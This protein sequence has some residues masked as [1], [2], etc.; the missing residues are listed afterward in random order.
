MGKPFVI[1]VAGGTGSGK[2][3]F[4]KNIL[5]ALRPH[6]VSVIQHD[7]YYR[8]RSGIP[9]DE[10]A[11]INYDHPN[12]LETTLLIKHL[13][14]LKA[15]RPVCPPR[16]NF[17]TH[18][19]MPGG[20]EVRPTPVIIVEGILLFAEEALRNLFDLKIFVQTEADLRLLRRLQ[21]DLSERGR[22]FESAVAQYLD[23]VRPMHEMFV[24]PSKGYADIIV[25]AS[26][27]N[28]KAIRMIVDLIR[29][30]ADRT[31]RAKKKRAGS[32]KSRPEP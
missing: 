28:Q 16:Y 26:R 21:R 2:T 32:R 4:T 12:A 13:K 23:S 15:G 6:H 5:Q 31:R 27:E 17:V 19:R 11:A 14:A 10:R 30:Q 24:E 22:S 25:P 8:D 1:G 20:E 29:R 3:T 9:E 7:W 18:T